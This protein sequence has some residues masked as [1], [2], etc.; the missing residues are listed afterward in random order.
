MGAKE[1][2]TAPG[3]R[4][5]ES[6]DPNGVS[7]DEQGP[8]LGPIRLLEKTAAGF[9]PH[10]IQYLNGVLSRI[11]ARPLECS[12]LMPGLR[13]I[14][15]ALDDGDLAR[16]M[17]GT[18]LLHLPALGEPEARRAAMAAGI[19]KAAPDDP[20]HPGWPKGTEG[21]TGGEF[22]PK[23]GKA[24]VTPD[25]VVSERMRRVLRRQAIREALKAL[26][27][28]RRV[29]RLVVEAASNAV[30]GLDVV[31]D[32][33]M[34][35]DIVD[36]AN[37]FEALKTET[38]AAAEFVSKGP[39]SPEDLVM[40]PED[41]SFASY[42]DFKKEDLAK[43]FGPAGDGYQYHHIVEQSAEGDVSASEVQSTRNIVG[44]PTLLW[45]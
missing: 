45:R 30:P 40:S 28:P 35:A 13:A 15:R 16:A 25:R 14:A 20:Q 3:H 33:A 32:A 34:A 1:F 22:R 36:M 8:A 5:L 2:E 18:Q 12:D 21:G 26:L 6:L 39:R 4:L 7:C 31:G 19:S 11:F 9:A 23:E 27:K 17:I 10:S 37:E 38:S 24:S 43:R 44:I 41:E 29:L 42:L